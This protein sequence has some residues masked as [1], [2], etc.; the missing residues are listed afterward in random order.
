MQLPMP[1]EPETTAYAWC[2]PR[3]PVLNEQ[4]SR[5]P[6]RKPPARTP[7]I[8]RFVTRACQPNRAQC[9]S[10]RCGRRGPFR[11]ARG[12]LAA[13]VQCAP[14]ASDA[15][16]RRRLPVAPRP[17]RRPTAPSGLL[18]LSPPFVVSKF[19][20][21]RF[22][23]LKGP[24]R[25]A[26]SIGL[27]E[28]A[29]A[30]DP[31]ASM[32]DGAPKLRLSQ[33]V[34]MV[35]MLGLNKFD[36]DKLGYRQHCEAAFFGIQVGCYFA[37]SLIEQKIA[38]A[39]DDPAAAKVRTPAKMV[40]GNEAEPAKE[41]TV[42]EYDEDKFKEL[43]TQQLM[44]RPPPSAPSSPISCFRASVYAHAMLGNG[45]K[46]CPV[47]YIVTRALAA[48][49]DGIDRLFFLQGAVILGCIYYYWRSLIPL[50]LQT[51]MTPLNLYENPL[52]QIYVMKQDVKRP[53]P[54][55]N[56]LGALGGPP[57]TPAGEEAGSAPSAI[58]DASPQT[59]KGLAFVTAE[60]GVSSD[61][62][63]DICR[64]VP[65]TADTDLENKSDLQGKIAVVARGVVPFA[66]KARR[67]TEAGAIALIVVNDEDT[68]YKCTAAGED[69][70]AI[71]LPVVCVGR[72]SGTY[73]EDGTRVRITGV[74]KGA[75]SVL[76]LV[77]VEDAKAASSDPT[78][79]TS[80]TS[81]AGSG[82]PEPAGVRKTA[83]GRK[84]SAKD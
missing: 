56:P 2:R 23:A 52:F 13:W 34:P 81:P 37:L 31:S 59:G 20:S 30:Q 48:G 16:T 74:A 44:V 78:P 65:L 28:G 71:T 1:Q 84:N 77:E 42:K 26:T 61:A 53:F 79:E 25:E 75:G 49:P 83:A 32:T 57:E 76:R 46:F 15:S 18:Q 41:Q 63:G 35:L 50:I 8:P 19:S 68:P 33:I 22:S 21:A 70:S 11:H 29:S 14:T 40:M 45:C 80:S 51:F 4:R 72:R 54:V 62:E 58:K 69:C 24:S 7:V 38:G 82:A 36:L 3:L 12:G 73:L 55:N 47:P 6:W 64:A 10:W 27:A 9:L 5:L 60:F 43:R 67:V 66:E 39:P 17:L